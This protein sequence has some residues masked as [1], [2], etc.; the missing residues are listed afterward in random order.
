MADSTVVL[1]IN[2]GSS[3]LKYQL[4][5][6]DSGVERAGGVASSRSASRR[7]GSP[8]MRRRCGLRSSSWP[9]SASTCKS[10]G[11]VAVGHRVVHGGKRFYRPTLLDD[12][13]IAEL[14]RAVGAGAAAQSARAAGNQGG[15][16]A[17]ARRPHVAVFDTAFFHDLPAAAATYAIDRELARAV[18]DPPLRISRHVAPLRQRAGRRLPGAAA[19]PAESDRA[20]PGQRRLGFG[21]RRRPAGRHVDGPDA[22][23]GVW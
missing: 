4:V 7:H 12:D 10:C 22:A 1:V 15:A 8:T 13:R 5:D 23:G 14:D 3:S 6:P 2:S 17:A 16:Q 18:A 9:R 20:A 11:L 21:D 19:G